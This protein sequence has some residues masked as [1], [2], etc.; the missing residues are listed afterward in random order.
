[1]SAAGENLGGVE[2][3]RAAVP[4]E[5]R[6][7]GVAADGVELLAQDFAADGE[8]LLRIAECGKK[9]GIEAGFAGDLSHHLHQAPGEAAR[10]GL[11]RGDLIV[12]I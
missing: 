7:R 12:C 11:G 10:V 2:R 1:M 9:Q 6:A 3:V 4:G 5:Q 8:A